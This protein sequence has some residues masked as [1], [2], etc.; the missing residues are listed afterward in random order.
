MKNPIPGFTKL[1]F[2]AD[3]SKKVVYFYCSSNGN[4]SMKVGVPVHGKNNH[5][6]NTNSAG[7]KC[8]GFVRCKG[9]RIPRRRGRKPSGGRQ[10]MILPN[11]AKKCMKLR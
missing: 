6:L 3:L 11:F 2:L 5:H 9:F 7:S 10:D 8:K 1:Y 4:R